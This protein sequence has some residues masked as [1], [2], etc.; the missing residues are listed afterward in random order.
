MFYDS[1]N[2]GLA[3]ASANG[4]MSAADKQKLDGMSGDLKRLGWGIIGSNG[5][6]IGKSDSV[7]G[8]AHNGTGK[9]DIQHTIGHSRYIVQATVDTNGTQFGYASVSNRSGSWFTIRTAD[10]STLNDFSFAFQIF[11]Y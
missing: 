10:D 3:S 6:T 5:T 4:L 2:L 8:A 11:E 1:G 9:Y 7:I